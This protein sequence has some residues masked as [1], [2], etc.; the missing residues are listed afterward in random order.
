[1]HFNQYAFCYFFCFDS[2]FLSGEISKNP[3]INARVK[4]LY[5]PTQQPKLALRFGCGERTSNW[6]YLN[7]AAT[8][9][10]VHLGVRIGRQAKGELE[11]LMGRCFCSSVFFGPLLTPVPNRRQIN[12]VLPFSSLSILKKICCSNPGRPGGNATHLKFLLSPGAVGEAQLMGAQDILE[13][14]TV[15]SVTSGS[16]RGHTED[17]TQLCTLD[18]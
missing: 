17:L 18:S 3:E 14:W 6:L 7:Y 2:F 4:N 15:C 16:H 11:T 13:P 12:F 5:I 9:S 8:V 10:P 1:M